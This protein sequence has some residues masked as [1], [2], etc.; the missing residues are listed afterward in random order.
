MS[1][2]NIPSIENLTISEKIGL[3]ELLWHDISK[4]PENVEV[5]E[6]HRQILEER[7][8]AVANG[9]DEF[10]DFDEAMAQIRKSIETRRAG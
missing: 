4:D 6:W 1:S 7:E 9:E 3:M 2:G 8:R 5:P 10:I